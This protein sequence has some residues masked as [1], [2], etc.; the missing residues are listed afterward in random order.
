MNDNERNGLQEII[1]DAIAAMARE[2]GDSFDLSRINLAEFARRTGLSRSKART[3]KAKGFKATPH[4]RCG[5]KAARTVI[6]GFEGVV[7]ALLKEGVVNSEVV[8]ERLRDRG[9]EGGRTTVKNY[10]AAHADLVPSKRRLA[11]RVPGG[12]RG[13]RYETAPGEAY[14]MDWGFVRVRDWTDGEFRIAC[15][16]MMCHHC[17]VCYIEFFPNARQENLF[18]GMIHGFLTL[19]VPE[20][21]LTDNMK[22]VTTGRDIDGRP[23]WQVDYAAFMACVGFKTKLCKPYH[24]FTKGKVERL[25]GFVKGNFLAGRRFH[26]VTD[27]NAQALEWCAKHSCR[28]RRALDCVPADEHADKCLSAA[29]V[30]ERTEELAMYLCP[31]RRVSFDGFV[32]YEGRRFGVPYWYEGKTCR[33][34]RDGR[35][36]HVYAED[37]SRELAVHPVTWSR[38]DSFCEDQYADV[39]PIELPTAPITT[40]ITQ[41]KPPEFKLGFEKFDFEGRL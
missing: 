26:D 22:S 34:S 30:L 13:R 21:V 20:F 32:N 24:P 36:L 28:Y 35:W 31:R 4:G 29:N 17:G 33:V 14:Q 41:T 37:L 15:F 27:L 7:D 25:I 40:V 11:A 12:S 1:D 23:I 10:M 16:A 19:G 18:I 38:K 5:V 8:F 2:A 9:Y 39:E 3:L 6:S